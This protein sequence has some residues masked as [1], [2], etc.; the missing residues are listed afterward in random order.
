MP[1][2]RWTVEKIRAMAPAFSTRTDLA[3]KHGGAYRFARLIPGLLDELFGNQKFVWDKDGLVREASKY[4][5]KAAF[6]R[7]SGGAYAA[8]MVRFPGLID[9]LFDNQISYW[10][11]ESA[12]ALEAE[13]YNTRREFQKGA[14]GAYKSALS[15]FP[16]LLEQIFGEPLVKPWA[17]EG[18][19]LEAKKYSSRAEFMVESGGAYA[20]ILKFPG[21]LD[22][23][24]PL[25][26][27]YWGNEDDIREEA[28][29]YKTKA[30]FISGCV[31]A[32]GAA[33]ELGIID[34]LG[35][36]PGNSGFDTTAPA[37]IY[38]AELTLKDGKDAV[39]FGITNRTPKGRYTKAERSFM[40]SLR[41][42]MF[43]VGSDALKIETMLRREFIAFAV[44]EGQSPLLFKKGTAGEIVQDIS[45]D[46]V[47]ERLM[48]AHANLPEME[49]WSVR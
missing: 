36:S 35:F 28:S 7:N 42:F 8:C 47:L 11:D 25:K 22:K 31:S 39:L 17:L 12:V 32:Y 18:L 37:Y 2:A 6:K 27:R 30:E 15:K 5:T 33:L 1:G 49:E 46:A 26:Y 9:A 29:K 4:D 10:K 16:H 13:K 41:A 38:L 21:E 45:V 40:R 19:I 34:D 20:A 44:G 3:K 23:I 14:S 24:F 48:S 43:D